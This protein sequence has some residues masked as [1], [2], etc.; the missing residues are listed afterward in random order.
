VIAAAAPHYVPGAYKPFLPQ[1]ATA[2]VAVAAAP[3]ER[4]G[5]GEEEADGGDVDFDEL[6]A[7]CM[8]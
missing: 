2:T 6:F 3:A 5:G 4:Q 8:G 7:L 1:A